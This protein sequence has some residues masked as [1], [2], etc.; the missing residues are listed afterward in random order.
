MPVNPTL[1]PTR[2][3]WRSRLTRRRFLA[4]AALGACGVG[5]YTWRIEPHWVEVVER[6]LPIAG[7]PHDLHDR[8]LVQLSDFHVG[9]SVDS[10]YLIE[11][12]KRVA[13]L[14]PDL[15]VITGDFM[16]CRSTEQVDNVCRVLE[17]L[18]PGRLGC[19]AIFGNH[20]YS[21]GWSNNDVAEMLA[22]RLPDFGIHLLRN[23]SRSVA[24]LQVVGIDD[25]WSPNFRPEAV[26]L[27][28]NWQKPTLT[29]CHNPDAVDS[30]LLAD[31]RGWILSGH[32]H[33][34]QCK[35]A[36]SATASAARAKPPLHLRRIRPRQRPPALYQPRPGPFASRA[37]QRSA[38]NYGV[39]AVPGVRIRVS[40]S[41][42][43]PCPARQFGG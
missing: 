5:L 17:H 11:C 10:G 35:T 33:G 20:D 13:T 7:L 37:I 21:L 25:L 39:S 32:T 43:H 22:Q 18:S 34:G 40:C 14:E 4:V 41:K 16:T 19:Y 6:D 28:V 1:S 24:G 36:V 42:G 27:K 38:G 8:R 15:T 23:E 29:L 12:L 2:R 9:R 30:S 31:G 26:V 3:T